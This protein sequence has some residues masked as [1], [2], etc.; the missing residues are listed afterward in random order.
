[1]RGSR[2]GLL[3]LATGIIWAV[4]TSAGAQQPAQFPPGAVVQPLDSG[5]GAQLRENLTTLASNPRSIQALIGAGR[6]ALSMGDA[7]AALGFFARADEVAPRDARVKAGM[8][9]ALVEMEHGDTALPLFAE[10]VSLGAPEAEIVADRG[11]AYDMVGDPRR[12]Q[13]DYTAALRRGPDAEVERRLALSLAISGQRE[14]ALRVLERQLSTHDRAGWRTQAFVLALTGDAA[15][16]NDTAGRMMPAGAARDMAPF[17]ARLAALSPSQKAMAVH[18]GRFPSDGRA[19]A[20]RRPVD[21]SADP[22]ALALAGVPPAP[23]PG[24]T[25]QSRFQPPSHPQVQLAQPRAQAPERRSIQPRRR[26]GAAE[27]PVGTLI[28]RPEPGPPAPAVER[29]PVASAQ[30]QPR[31]FAPTSDTPPPVEPPVRTPIQPPFAAPAQVPFRAPV[32]VAANEG[33]PFVPPQPAPTRIQPFAAPTAGGAN[34]GFILAPQGTQPAPSAPLPSAPEAAP[35]SAPLLSAPEAAPPPAAAERPAFDQIAALVAS[36]PAEEVSLPPARPAPPV[37]RT[38]APVTPA[39]ARR[40]ETATA[41]SR[42][43]AGEPAPRRA[44]R[45]APPA[46]PSRHW[47][48]LATGANRAGLPL[49]FS[50]MREQSGTLL[51]GRTAYTARVAAT[52]RLLVGPF[53]TPRAAQLFVNQLAQHEI[54]ALAWTSPAGQE[55]ER[56]QTRR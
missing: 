54:R 10:A 41:S 36:L 7:E 19:I 44:A 18:F 53:D 23:R 48:Q 51:T 30:V 13:Q 28:R 38:P 24:A 49:T 22:G 16:A 8:A 52:N 21:T 34:A 15:G 4:A 50:Q 47:V 25:A 46:N 55:I 56:L 2:R 14:A 32:Q 39:P 1:M 43:R 26:P 37:A 33:P 31:R 6:A 3:L 40:P 42:T 12:A 17:F 27:A 45:P 29:R 11:L 9:S 35:P 5:A 20:D